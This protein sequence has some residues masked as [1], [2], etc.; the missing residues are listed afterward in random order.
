MNPEYREAV[1]SQLA[2]INRTERQN[3]L[4]SIPNGWRFV[5]E[6]EAFCKEDEFGKTFHSVHGCNWFKTGNLSRY[7]NEFVYITT[8]PIPKSEV[9][10][11]FADYKAEAEK[12]GL[13]VDVRHYRKLDPDDYTIAFPK[14]GQ[15]TVSLIAKSGELVGLG[16]AICSDS[17]NY[18]KEKGRLLAI[19]RALALMKERVSSEEKATNPV[20]P[21]TLC[22]AYS[23]SVSA[24]FKIG[25]YVSWKGPGSNFIH[26]PKIIKNIPQSGVIEILYVENCLILLD[27][28]KDKIWL[29]GT[30][31][32]SGLLTEE[33]RRMLGIAQR[34]RAGGRLA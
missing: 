8:R 24:P 18:C 16:E 6:D 2:K 22:P 20:T 10:E 11:T 29:A 17:D 33:E 21:V 15:T 31:E 32:P 19:K 26:G 7:C 34:I 25:D 27:V 14:G 30:P 28:C 13:E 1:A 4:R 3:A 5:M 12:I 23:S 9:Q